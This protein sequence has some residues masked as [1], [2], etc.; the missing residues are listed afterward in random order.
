MDLSVAVPEAKVSKEVLEPALESVTR[1]N[2]RM[3]EKGEVPTA[4]DAIDHDGVRWKPEPPGAERFDHA[5]LVMRRKWGDCDDLA[6][7]HAA[8]LRV[9]GEDH[10]AQAIVY[11]SGPG[12]WHAVV[13]RSDGSI[14]A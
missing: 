3:I 9:T 10:G 12:R 4:E 13:R 11:P 7:W 2:E 6:P 14:A 1:L 8:S 5:G